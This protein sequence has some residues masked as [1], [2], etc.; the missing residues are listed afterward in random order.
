MG[1]GRKRRRPYCCHRWARWEMD[2]RLVRHGWPDMLFF[3]KLSRNRNL[4][5]GGR[6]AF[7]VGG[8]KI[9]RGWTVSGEIWTRFL[10]CSRSRI[11]FNCSPP[12]PL[13][14]STYSCLSSVLVFLPSHC[15][16]IW[17]S[18]GSRWEQNVPCTLKTS[19]WMLIH[20]LWSLAA[21]SGHSVCANIFGASVNLTYHDC[22]R[23]IKTCPVI[24]LWLYIGS[25]Q[26]NDFFFLEFI[27]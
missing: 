12:P 3:T 27:W 8:G 15:T 7:R 18:P 2:G 9:I 14:L 5:L 23:W 1:E 22:K 21:V 6:R 16:S 10:I 4:Q 20:V 19:P 17:L 25:H 24:S 11:R 13:S 26:W